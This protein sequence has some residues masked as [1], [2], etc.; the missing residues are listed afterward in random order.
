MKVRV[1]RHLAGKYDV[2]VEVPELLARGERADLAQV[3]VE[4]IL[5]L[6]PARL[7]AEPHAVRR[8]ES[9]VARRDR[10]PLLRGAAAPSGSRGGLVRLAVAVVTVVGPKAAGRGRVLRIM[11]MRN[12]ECRE[13][14]SSYLRLKLIGRSHGALESRKQGVKSSSTSVTAEALHNVVFE[15]VIIISILR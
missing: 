3:L 1:T 12:T 7:A 2:A 6:L 15:E 8:L 9:V 11:A 10:R 14:S 13:Y 5:S 4:R